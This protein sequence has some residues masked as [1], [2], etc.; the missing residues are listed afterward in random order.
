MADVSESNANFIHGLSDLWTRFFRDRS[1]LET[2]YKGAEIPM[3]QTYLDLMATVLNFSLRE[4]PVFQKEFFKLVT[5]REDLVTLRA[6]D[7]RYEFEL[8]AEGIKNFPFLYN[9]IFDPTVILEEFLHFEV[10]ISGDKDL[11]IFEDDPFDYDGTGKPI[12]GVAY[13]DVTVLADDGSTSVQT[14]LAFWAPDV[15]I[16]GY[17]M[18]LNFGYLIS[19]FEPSSEAYRAL[20][21]G[22]FQYFVLGPTPMH[23]TSALNVIVGFPVI[24]DEGEI[25][26]EVDTSDADYNVVV[27]NTARYSLDSAIPI[28]DDILDENNWATN[29][30]DDSALTL[31]AL[32]YIT[33]VFCVYDVI[34]NP[35]WWNDKLIP[36]NL[37]PDEPKVRRLIH[38]TLYENK[39]NNPPGLVKVGDPGVFCGADEDGFVPVLDTEH[40][41][42]YTGPGYETNTELWRPTYR[43]SFSYIAFERFLKHHAYIVEMDHATLQAGI[44]PFS[45]LNFDLQNVVAAGKSAYTYMYAEAGLNFSDNVIPMDDIVEMLIHVGFLHADEPNF[46]DA[47]L[48]EMSAGIN[49]T[50]ITGETTLLVGDYYKYNASGAIDIFHAPWPGWTDNDGKT[51]IVVGGA[52][53]TRLDGKW[54]EGSGNGIFAY[55]AHDQT[56]YLKLSGVGIMTSYLVGSWVYRVSTQKFYEIASYEEIGGTGTKIYF[57]TPVGIFADGFAEDWSIWAKPSIAGHGDM[58]VQIEVSTVP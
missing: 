4:V 17:D 44:I 27:T 11:L 12:P 30:G 33:T 55:V 2:M 15:K 53:P 42:P 20:L 16:D 43:H 14:E 40:P 57:T 9:K 41:T 24:R 23:L 46:E 49:N 31:K 28:R 54:R 26:Q 6:S 37:L 47:G 25:L 32:E 34:E 21:Q 58:A 1:Q 5:V 29:V 8:T 50:I 51:P 48:G 10:D 3:G 35:T 36:E 45:R 22:I 56:G 39:V 18:Y 19:R 7:A 38:P 52:D 13:R